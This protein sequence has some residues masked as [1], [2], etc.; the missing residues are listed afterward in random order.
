MLI[1]FP[2]I[3]LILGVIA[4][5]D[6]KKNPNLKGRGMTIAGIIIII[7]ILIFIYTYFGVF[8]TTPPMK[9]PYCALPM[10]LH[11][12]DFSVVAGNPGYITLKIESMMGQGIMIRE[13]NI[14]SSTNETKG[15]IDLTKELPGGPK[16]Y[17]NL[18]G[19]HLLSGEEETVKIICNIKP[20]EKNKNID[21]FI[22]YCED[23]S[24]NNEECEQFLHTME[25]EII[26]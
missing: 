14:T 7:L 1:L 23:I 25:G 21:I 20:S 18:D 24:T 5:F 16:T 19:W 10:G 6:I 26:N 2:I 15:Y 4:L 13:I 11:C 8:A 3:G 12:N 9:R 17:N 22:S